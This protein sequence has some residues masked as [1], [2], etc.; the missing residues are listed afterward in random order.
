MACQSQIGM[1]VKV[2]SGDR[3]K[4]VLVLGVVVIPL[5]FPLSEVAYMLETKG[6]SS[7]L[8]LKS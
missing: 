1:Q 3:S 5:P 7:Q 6:S 2:L 8:E 4:T